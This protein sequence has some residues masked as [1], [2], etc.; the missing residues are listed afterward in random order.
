MEDGQRSAMGSVAPASTSCTNNA[1]QPSPSR[2]KGNKNVRV[3]SYQVPPSHPVPTQLFKRAPTRPVLALHVAYP[4]SSY[5]GQ[6]P[7]SQVRSHKVASSLKSL[8]SSLRLGRLHRISMRRRMYRSCYDWWVMVGSGKKE[9]GWIC[10]SFWVRSGRC[11]AEG[12]E[13]KRL[14]ATVNSLAFIH[15]FP[16]YLPDVQYYGNTALMFRS[17]HVHRSKVEQG[18]GTFG[19]QL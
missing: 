5:N 15:Q 4:S 7:L 12:S 2:R 9:S 13:L 10:E 14:S 19:L 6:G 8:T 11:Q 16:S 1:E 3:T 17:A 18:K